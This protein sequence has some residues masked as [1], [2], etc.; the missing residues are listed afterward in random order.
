[1]SSR[2]RIKVGDWAALG[3]DAWAIRQEVFVF[4]QAVPEELEQ[5]S[6]DDVSIHAVAYDEL[7]TPLGTGRLLPDGHIGRMAVLRSARGQGIGGR[8][9]TQLIDIAHQSSHE[10]VVLNAQVHARAFYEAHGFAVDGSVFQ[11]AGID[12]VLMRRHLR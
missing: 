8:I 6:F 1:M 4:E 2:V 5:D 3:G 10:R 7:D 9:L 12:H 11:D